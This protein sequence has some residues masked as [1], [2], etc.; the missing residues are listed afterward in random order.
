MK[1][2]PERG[3]NLAQTAKAMTSNPLAMSSKRK[4]WRRLMSQWLLKTNDQDDQLVLRRNCH[5]LNV[6]VLLRMKPK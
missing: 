3:R 2:R 6:N 5:L 1:G 4:A